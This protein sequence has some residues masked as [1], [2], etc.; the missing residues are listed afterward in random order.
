MKLFS[1]MEM[2]TFVWDA[3]VKASSIDVYM[4]D[5]QYTV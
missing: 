3:L 2:H 1:K 4:N 5:L